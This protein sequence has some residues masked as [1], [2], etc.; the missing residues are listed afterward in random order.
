[1]KLSATSQLCHDIHHAGYDTVCMMKPCLLSSLD[2]ISAYEYFNR[3]TENGS[4]IAQPFILIYSNTVSTGLG[5]DS[6]SQ[7]IYTSYRPN[8]SSKIL[9]SEKKTEHTGVNIMNMLKRGNF[10]S[11]SSFN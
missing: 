7:N 3:R 10:C 9:R 1:M 6:S 11:I 8:T 4:S 5:S 2:N